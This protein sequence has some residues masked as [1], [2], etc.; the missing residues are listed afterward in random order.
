MLHMKIPV[1]GCR[2]SIVR[3]TVSPTLFIVVMVMLYTS[4][5]SVAV[6]NSLAW[7]RVTLEMVRPLATTTLICSGLDLAATLGKAQAILV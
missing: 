2:Y 5:G 6:W 3:E 4:P 1:A 7:S